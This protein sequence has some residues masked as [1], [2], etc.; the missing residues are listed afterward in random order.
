VPRPALGLTVFPE[1]GHLLSPELLLWFSI[2][3]IEFFVLT[4]VMQPLF[5]TTRILFPANFSSKNGF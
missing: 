4:I 1:K 2:D 3:L 5:R